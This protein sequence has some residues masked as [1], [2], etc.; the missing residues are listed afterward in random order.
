[1]KNF[2]LGVIAIILVGI[3]GLVYRNA[4]ERRGQVIACPMDAKVCPDGSS[5]GRVGTSC[6]FPAC[7][8]PNVSLSDLGISFAAPLGF[9]EAEVSNESVLIAYELTAGTSTEASKI[10]LRRFPITASSTALATIQE[11]AIGD[12]SGLPVSATAYT[13]TSL[14]SHRFTVVSIGR[15]EGVVTTAYYLAREADVLRFDAIDIGVS[16]WANPTLETS[17]LP[18]HAG[19]R[20]LLQTLSGI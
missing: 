10:I 1:M 12:A 20:A 6:V 8:P 16:D 13:S 18:A 7:P 5:V 17:V 11:T 19:T 2:L 3:G 4:I 9:A 15:F 14:G